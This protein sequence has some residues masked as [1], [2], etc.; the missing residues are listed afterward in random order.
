MKYGKFDG[1]EKK[2]SRFILGTMSIVDKEDL[3]EDFKRLDDALETGINTLDTAM[4]YGRGTT[5]IALGKYFKD[6]KNRDEFVVISKACHPS[7]WR[8]RVTPFDLS[9]DL[10]DALV[11]MGTDHLDV[12]M[13]HRDD[14]SVPV[15]ILMDTLDQ[16]HREGKILSYG[17]SNWTVKRIV[18]ANQYAKENGLRPITVSSP[19]YSLAEQYCEPWAPGC[20]TISGPE[21]KKEREWYAKEKMPV[22]AYSSMARGLFSGRVTKE[23]FEKNSEEIDPF[24]AKAYCGDTN[25]TRLERAT[26][27]AREKGVEV[28]Q[29][30]LAFIMN[31]DMDVYPIIG[32]LTKAELESSIGALDVTL[33]AN[34][35]AWLD[36]ESDKR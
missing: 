29:I 35:V 7:P 12:Y 5:E 13:L 22:L 9:A 25:F 30:A 21:N 15:E 8:K 20:I 32:A 24:C 34:E 18:E 19:N 3:S 2:V 23:L 11:K 6:R 10:H 16:H 36:L 33:T 1:V 14:E 26:E 27:L 28:P 4:G 17:V 31:G